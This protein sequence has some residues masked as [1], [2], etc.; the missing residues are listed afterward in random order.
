MEQ[1]C[2]YIKE[3]KEQQKKNKLILF[4]IAIAVILFYKIP[5]NLLSELFKNTEGKFCNEILWTA[6]GAIGGIISFWGVIMT[7]I[8]TEKSRTKQNSYDYIKN[9][10]ELELNQLKAEVK[11]QLDILNPTNA[12][13]ISMKT[14][15]DDNYREISTQLNLY[16]CKARAV[17]RNIYWYYDVR[18]ISKMIKYKEFVEI[19]TKDI[20]QISEIINNYTSHINNWFINKSIYRSLRNLEKCT[21]L[22]PKEKEELEKL[23][24]IYEDVKKQNEA[25]DTILQYK[26]ELIKI[27]NERMPILENKA[28][29]MIDE[30]NKAIRDEL[31]CLK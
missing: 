10:K 3:I 11:K 2:K 7:I 18:N 31:N 17:L 16:A 13:E 27:S 1:E 22:E 20:A 15:D 30:R 28:K 5:W 29:E 6:L 9:Q 8:Y 12:I 21:Q 19:A 14:I 26:I 23:K 24:L 4:A 25:I